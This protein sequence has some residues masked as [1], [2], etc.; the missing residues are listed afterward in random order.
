MKK[1]NNIVKLVNK[2]SEN[3]LRQKT[4]FDCALVNLGITFT[5]KVKKIVEKV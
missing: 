3:Q 1:Q 5:P 4:G 2:K